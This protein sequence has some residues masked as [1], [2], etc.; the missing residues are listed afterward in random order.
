MKNAKA[1]GTKIG[2]PRR[3]FDRQQA[4]DMRQQGMSYPA[5][6]R[7]MGVGYGTVVRGIESLSK[8]LAAEAVTTAL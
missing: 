6:A 8:K 5:I 3:V 4:L 7:A 2:R 1:N